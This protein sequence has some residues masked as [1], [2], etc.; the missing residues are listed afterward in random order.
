[1]PTRLQVDS[2][3][4]LDA[5]GAGQLLMY[6]RAST[7]YQAVPGAFSTLET[8]LTAL[9][10]VDSTKS[11]QLSA[12]LDALEALGPDGTVGV[13]GGR[14][15]VQYSLTEDREQILNLALNVLYD[16]AVYGQGTS[17]IGAASM[18]MID[19]DCKRCG[20]CLLPWYVC[21]SQCLG[22]RLCWY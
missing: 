14:Y 7:S 11:K 6:L 22:F 12:L 5:I 20:V 9:V 19:P 2:A 4:P 18:Q 10:A 17:Q 16:T 1:M 13:R 15:G 21:N 8:D 3:D